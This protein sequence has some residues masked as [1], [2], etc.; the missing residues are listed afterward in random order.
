MDCANVA[1]SV[2]QGNRVILNG[3]SSADTC[4]VITDRLYM[5]A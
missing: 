3:S 5:T 2:K 4:L 1:D